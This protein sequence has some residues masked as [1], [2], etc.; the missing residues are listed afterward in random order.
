MPG[1]RGL[2]GLCQIVRRAVDDAYQALAEAAYAEPAL[3]GLFPLTSHGV[4][5]FS[6]T[7]RP[8]LSIVGPRLVTCDVDQYSLA[9]TIEG[10][11]PAQFATAPET[12]AAAVRRL[13][14]GLASVALGC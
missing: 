7:T 8:R 1:P 12:V 14:Y 2:H 9:M 6:A 4:L 5:T 3:R 11:E 10:E 13:P